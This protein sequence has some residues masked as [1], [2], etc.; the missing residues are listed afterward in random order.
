MEFQRYAIVE[1]GLGATYFF[2]PFRRYPGMRGETE[3]PK[4]RAAKYDLSEL[5][6][7]VLYLRNN[8]CE[9]GVHGIDAWQS[10]KKGQAELQ[11]VGET[12]GTQPAGIRMHWLYWSDESPGV[13]EEAG[14]KY[15]STFGYNAAIGF[16]A[17]TGQVFRPLSANRLLELPLIIQDSAMFYSDR[18]ML[19]EKAALDASKAL[20]RSLCLY[21][22]V[23]TVNWHT[24]SLSPER[25]WGEFYV[26]LL[27]EV[28]R[29]R[30]WFGTAEKVVSWFQKRRSL[31]F[32]EVGP[33]QRGVRQLVLSVDSETPELPFCVR[34]HRRDPI[35]NSAS[36]T[37]HVST[38]SDVL[39]LASSTIRLLRIQVPEA[40]PRSCSALP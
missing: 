3:A 6:D 40:H 15:D 31:Q 36:Y 18:M 17:G 24:R 38:G 34:L 29:F 19:S 37:D 27:Q 13:L 8:G 21:G 32:R 4:R 10:T 22:G 9:I 12:T 28:K 1:K 5:K 14:F 16:R 23:L 39:E 2:I 35:T 7:E 26:E 25:L 33:S 11:H 20:V 30:V